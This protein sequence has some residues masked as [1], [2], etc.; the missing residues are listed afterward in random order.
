MNR[1]EP[2]EISIH[3]YQLIQ[4]HARRALI[5]ANALGLFP[6]RVS[7]IMAAAK[8][9]VDD[10]AEIDQSFLDKLRRDAGILLKSAWQKVLGVFDTRG[11]FAL[12][13]KTVVV[14]KQTF[15]KLHELGHGILPWQRDIY[16]VIEECSSTLDP[17]LADLFDQEANVF[18][19]EV[20]FQIDAFSEEA[21]SFGFG[22]DVPLKLAK[23]YGASAYS[24]IRRY[25]EKSPKCCTV[26]VFNPPEL[27][28][29]DG[30][31]CSFIRSVSSDTFRTIFG[32]IS[33]PEVISPDDW[34]GSMV[35]IG[36]KRM[37]G[38]R[39]VQLLDANGDMH[40]CVG[41]VFTQGY[42]VFILIHATEGLGASIFLP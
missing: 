5:D 39:S 36:N 3:Q 9:T 11:R 22:V 30:F 10:K 23:K 6:T 1:K 29:T 20:L 24:S 26:L 31:T 12:I 8:I 7:D 16:G 41:E 37:S 2:V 34:L 40:R 42:Q 25:V 32:K 21:N 19:A 15:I 13:D 14:V 27:K 18:A 33:W 4:Q 28:S 17:E 35:P 38:K